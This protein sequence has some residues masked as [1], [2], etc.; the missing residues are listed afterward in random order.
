MKRNL[1]VIYKIISPERSDIT[2]GLV[3]VLRVM[4]VFHFKSDYDMG[5]KNG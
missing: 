5:R 3:F 2:Q 1:A 4:G